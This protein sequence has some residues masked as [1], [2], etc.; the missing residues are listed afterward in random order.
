MPF[1]F[2]CELFYEEVI[3]LVALLA[4][5]GTEP[6]PRRHNGCRV[7]ISLRKGQEPPDFPLSRERFILFNLVRCNPNNVHYLIFLVWTASR[8]RPRIAGSRYLNFP[9][10]GYEVT[11]RSRAVSRSKNV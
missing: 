1:S 8:T 3:K 11:R 7:S 4:H 9:I 6:V 5:E 10:I 2:L